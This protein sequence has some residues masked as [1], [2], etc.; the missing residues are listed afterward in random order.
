MDIPVNY[1][2][3]IVCGIVSMV[4]GSIWFGPLFGKQW[5]HL[6]GWSNVDA[7]KKAEMMKGMQKSYLF[8][9]IGALVMAYVLSH[10][11]VFASTYMDV[12]GVSAGL[13][14]GFWMWL[15]F[16]APVT[17]SSVLWE[18]K[19]WKLWILTSGYYLVQL[20]IFGAIL[21]SWK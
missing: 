9:F 19:S 13:S 5:Q 4:L 7:A 17:L 6:M 8:A 15:G 1:W 11:I 20:L 10:S 16:I 14:S 3:V 12:S 21:A 18:G 2:A